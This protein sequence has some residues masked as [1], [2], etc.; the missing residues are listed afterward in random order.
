MK[1]I[2]KLLLIAIFSFVI[3][4]S[5]SGLGITAK[6]SEGDI[7]GGT[8]G[9]GISWVIGAD[10]T[11]TISGSGEAFD[12]S[13]YSPPWI[14]YA[15]QIT[16]VK[17]EEGITKIPDSLLCS[18]DYTSKI[19]IPSTVSY[20]GSVAFDNS[21]GIG[22]YVVAADNENFKSEDGVL[23]SKDGRYLIRFPSAHHAE[24]FAVPESVFYIQN[25]AFACS[26]TL[27]VLSIGEN[28]LTMGSNFLYNTM[29]EEIIFETA[30]SSIPSCAFS[31]CRIESFIVPDTVE[32]LKSSIF[33]GVDPLKTLVIG[34]GVKEIGSYLVYGTPNL[35][36]IHYNGTAES[37]SSVSID[38]ENEDLFAKEIHYVSYKDGYGATCVDGHEGGLYCEEC[39]A[40]LTGEI[41]PSVTDHIPGEPEI[42]VDPADCENGA[43]QHNIIYCTV[44]EI[45]ISHDE[46]LISENLGHEWSDGICL[47]CGEVCDHYDSDYDTDCNRCDKKAV[48]SYNY[49]YVDTVGSVRC[50]DGDEADEILIFIPTQSGYYVITSDNGDDSNSDPIVKIY[51]S[52]GDEIA[53]GDD[54]GSS[55]NFKVGFNA[56][57]GRIYAIDLG[58][59]NSEDAT[60]QYLLTKEHRIE[61]QPTSEDTEVKV[62]GDNASYQWYEYIV[63]EEITD[64]N[65]EAVNTYG[66][67]SGYVQDK[68]WY[69][70]Y[71]ADGE[72]SFFTIELKQGESILINFGCFVNG[73]TGIWDIDVGDGVEVISD[74]GSVGRFIFTAPFD[75]SF[76]IYSYDVEENA[77]I[78][79]YKITDFVSIEGENSSSLKDPKIGKVYAC[80]VSIG[81][82]QLMSEALFYDY[83]IIGFPKNDDPTVKVNAGEATYQWSQMIFDEEYTSGNAEIVDWGKGAS[84]YSAEGGWIGVTDVFGNEICFDYFT[85]ELAADESIT[86]VVF[87]DASCVGI[88]DYEKESGH[89]IG[90][91]KGSYVYTIKAAEAGTYTV[92][93]MTNGGE[94]RLKAYIGEVEYV[95]IDGATNSSYYAAEDGWYICEVTFA[96]GNDA[97][98]TSYF[99]AHQHKDENSDHLCDSCNENLAP[100][101]G[102]GNSG[103]D[104]P[105]TGNSGTDE[106]STGNQGTADGGE[107]NPDPEKALT[108]GQVALIVIGSLAVVGIG[109]FSV[110]WFVVKKKSFADLVSII[111]NKV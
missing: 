61:K 88:Y 71:W 106:P 2:F 20:I 1:N 21:F 85:V 23:Y 80:S 68:G 82:A 26:R 45:E 18:L 30:A 66:E 58:C 72:A 91:V 99:S 78:K 24:E 14:E 63:G 104:E 12:F 53:L 36:I 43:H 47:T 54:Y 51:N 29:V 60:Y 55:L 6:A 11:L 101:P 64:K 108:G 7:A 27:K 69:G 102:T 73:N 95:E 34:S 35:S 42:Y 76:E 62:D 84:S 49:I 111:K 5:I 37:W 94:I 74:N 89:S 8:V 48:F 52:R 103:A 59:F 57:E 13:W 28:V 40:Y 77:Y 38:A 31:Y 32:K 16:S 46:Y 33:F 65:A 96:N 100:D 83:A 107:N 79:A 50:N 93:A 4:F 81:E 110:V 70:D 17:I 98:V 92:Y 3:I 25:E 105:G 86:V 9:D 41:I 75:G 56:E 39:E 19:Y 10:G 44:C 22:E 90:C 87:G 15:D 67:G 109:V 97:V